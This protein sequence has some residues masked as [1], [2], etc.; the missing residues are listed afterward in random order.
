MKMLIWT[1][2]YSLGVGPRM[3]GFFYTVRAVEFILDSEKIPKNLVPVYQE[4]AKHYNVE[5]G[6]VTDR[7]RVAAQKA[8]KV[9][10]RL[11]EEMAGYSLPKPPGAAGFV[12]ILADHLRKQLV[13]NE[14]SY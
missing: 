8:W 6:N 14:G 11:L 2:L 5:V 9:D 10:R 4:V 12:Q 7:I 1:T 3:K 13:K